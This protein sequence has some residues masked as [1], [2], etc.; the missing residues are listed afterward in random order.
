MMGL[1]ESP[2]FNYGGVTPEN[3]AEKSPQSIRRFFLSGI[4]IHVSK[5]FFHVGLLL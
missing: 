4:G 1:E 2:F 5:T 3:P